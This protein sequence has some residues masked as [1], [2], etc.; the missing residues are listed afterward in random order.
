MLD[1]GLENALLDLVTGVV[2]RRVRSGTNV[3]QAVPAF[4]LEAGNPM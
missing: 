2:R 1:R 3:V 4:G